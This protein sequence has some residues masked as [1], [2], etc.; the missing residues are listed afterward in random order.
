[1]ERFL[2]GFPIAARRPSGAEKCW[3]WCR[4]NPGVATLA[5]G[6]LT[7]VVAGFGG[8]LWQWSQTERARERE[9]LARAEAA[10]RA[11]GVHKGIERLQAAA[12]HVDRARVFWQWRR[13]DDALEALNA[14]IA[15]RSDLGSAW[16][17]RARLYAELGLWELAAADERRAFEYNE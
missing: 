4:R 8:V 2:N 12:A 13:G 17:E 14:A 6:L 16:A 1:L 9:S 15:L 7:A 3:R 11:A 5:A 10:D